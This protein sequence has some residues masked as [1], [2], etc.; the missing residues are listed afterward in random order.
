MAI[1]C[2]IVGELFIFGFDMEKSPHNMQ[3][4]VIS[5]DGIVTD[6][7]V[8][9]IPKAVLMHDFAITEHYAIF[10]DLPLR[11]DPQVAIPHFST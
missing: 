9:T 4:R 3:Y 6:P 5:K 2:V 11:L 8:I 7:V 1:G 10:M